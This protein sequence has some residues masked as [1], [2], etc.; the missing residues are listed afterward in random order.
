M[1]MM[2]ILKEEMKNSLK[3]IK[4]KTKKMKHNKSLREI[5]ETPP[6]HTQN[7]IGEANSSRWED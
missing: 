3:K 2:E 1:K 6:T 7:H 5:Q 4:G